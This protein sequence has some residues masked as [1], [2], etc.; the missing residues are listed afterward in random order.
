MEYLRVKNWE[1][2][3][4]Y[5]DRLPPWIKLHRE[6]LTDYDFCHLP[7]ET[8]G[9]LMMTWLLASQMDGRIPDDA[10]W[11]AAR[12]GAKKPVNLEALISAGWLVREQPAS[13]PLARRKQ[14]AIVET[15]TYKATEAEADKPPGALAPPDWLPQ[16]VWQEFIAYRKQQKGWTAKAEVLLLRELE[17]LCRAGDDPTA[18]IEQSIANGWKGLFPLRGGRDSVRDELA[19]RKL[20]AARNMDILTGKVRNDGRERDISGIAERVDRAPVF[21]LPGDL[22]EPGGDDVEGSGP[23]RS[24]IGVG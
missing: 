3:Q 6:L 9:H 18:V 15:E 7:D 17:K 12:I 20:Q 10:R 14:S 4:H 22:R 16:P 11:I 5:K 21:A 13:K 19:E 2:F 1:E 8:K 23:A 24:A